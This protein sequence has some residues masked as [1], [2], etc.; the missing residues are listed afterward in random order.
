MRATGLVKKYN[1]FARRPG[2]ALLPLVLGCIDNTAENKENEDKIL[3]EW[4]SQELLE[5]TRTS[6]KTR[7]SHRSPLSQQ[8]I[9]TVRTDR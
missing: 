9:Q 4:I 5:P 6:K 2:L 1:L 3:P 8:D 7:S